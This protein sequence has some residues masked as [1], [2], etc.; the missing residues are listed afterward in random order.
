MKKRKGFTLIELLVVISIIALL[1]A[2]TIPIFRKAQETVREVVCRSNLRAVSIGMQMYFQSNEYRCPDFTRANGFLWFDSKGNLRS[3]KDWDTYWGV[4]F[5]KYITDPRIFGCPSFQRAAELIYPVDPSLI[6]YGAFGLNSYISQINI[7]DIRYPDSFIIAHDHVEPRSEQ[8]STDMFFNDG[9][10]TMNLKQY[11]KG[12]IRERF[13]RGIFRHNITKFEPFRT[14]GR[15]NVLWL[16]GHVD[17]IKETTGD[18][19]PRWWYT[20]KYPY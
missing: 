15:A 10:G 4:A 1:L 6:K 11:R 13:Y 2:I 9:P 14:G 7:Q 3:L 16:D 12:G 19:V 5:R 20:G 18:D 17:S 8:A